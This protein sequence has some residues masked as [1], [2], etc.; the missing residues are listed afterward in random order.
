[1][2][3]RERIFE[4]LVLRGK[5]A[6]EL[7]DYIGVKSSSISAWKSLESYPSSKHIPKISEFLNTTPTFLFT[8]QVERPVAPT[9]TL[10][11]QAILEKIKSMSEGDKFQLAGAIP[12]IRMMQDPLQTADTRNRLLT[13]VGLFTDSTSRD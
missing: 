11:D 2:D 10:G 9:L 4:L 1:M 7:G 6:K 5:T 13:S 12:F 3:V 8:G